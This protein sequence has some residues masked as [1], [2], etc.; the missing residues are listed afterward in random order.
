MLGVMKDMM[1][2]IDDPTVASLEDLAAEDPKAA[3]KRAIRDF[4][5]N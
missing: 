1:L 2:E 3:R 4:W 5:D